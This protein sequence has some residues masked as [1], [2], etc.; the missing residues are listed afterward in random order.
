ML[1]TAV[2]NTTLELI[3]RS[4]CLASK[5]RLFHSTDALYL[6]LPLQEIGFCFG[7]AMLMSLFR[8]LY[9]LLRSLQALRGYN[10]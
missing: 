6:K 2:R 4:G 5:D 3:K 7:N 9:P 1:K 8:K 10:P